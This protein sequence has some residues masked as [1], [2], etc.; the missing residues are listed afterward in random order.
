M[1]YVISFMA[2]LLLAIPAQAATPPLTGPEI[3]D[4]I[5]QGECDPLPEG[6]EKQ[7]K[8]YKLGDDKTLLAV[9]CFSGAYNVMHIYFAD[10]GKNGS[11]RLLPFSDWDGTGYTPGFALANVRF[12]ERSKTLRSLAKGRGIGDCGNAGAWEWDGD[13]FAMKSYWHKEPCDD[14]PFNPEARPLEWRIFPKLTD[15]EVKKAEENARNLTDG[16]AP[17]KKGMKK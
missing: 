11:W 9:P 7:T 5:A 14:T 15:A 6:W 10:D 2:A 4:G 3:A 16:I 12:D 13:N 8:T 17:R 1:Q